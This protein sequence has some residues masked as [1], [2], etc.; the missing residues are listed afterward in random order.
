MLA[1]LFADGRTSITEPVLSRDHSERIL[2][3][4]G[5]P[6]L[7]DGLTVSVDGPA[8]LT[9]CDINVPGDISSAAFFMI[10]AALVPDSEVTL[11]NVGVNP[12]REGVI[13]VL[14]MMGVPL[15]LSNQVVINGE[16]RADITVRSGRLKG[17][18]ISGGM[19]PRLIDEIPILAIAGTQ[20]Q[21]TFI[22]KNASELR[23]KETDRIMAIS[24]NLKRMGV[25]VEIFEDGFAIAGGQSL[26]GA[27]IET[28]G[29]HRMGM[30][31]SVAGL[32]ASG[33]TLIRDSDCAEISY[34]GFYSTLK[35]LIQHD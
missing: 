20:C 28:F 13:E 9:G 8:R 2:P 16:P 24:E 12:T 21:G 25:S 23:V 18:E 3:A 30:A 6:V 29:D 1:G 14:R 22:V 5:V 19:I 34:P 26:R 35:G 15:E 32:I 17:I 10:A 27:E 11:R 7:R 31:F 33:E 4:F